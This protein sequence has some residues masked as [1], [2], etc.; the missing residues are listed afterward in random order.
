MKRAKLILI[1]L[2]ISFAHSTINARQYIIRPAVGDI[3]PDIKMAN[4][5]GEIISLS[6]LRGKV[7]LVDFW[8]SWCRTCRI[9]NNTVRQAYTNYKNRN[10]SAGKGFD[11]FSVSLDQ[12]EIVWK[13]AIYND[14]LEWIH[15]VCDFKKWDSPVVS[16]YNFRSL[17]HNVLIDANGKILAKGLYGKKLSEFLESILAE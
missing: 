11:V 7:V 9:E 4:P 15:Q 8:A 1:V 10:F 13:K 3:A 6:S 16:S 2:C 5:K 12:D 14:R 17:P